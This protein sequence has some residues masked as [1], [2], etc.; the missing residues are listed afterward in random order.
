MTPT[1]VAVRSACMRAFVRACVCVSIVFVIPAAK[2][3]KSLRV[4]K[5]SNNT[6]SFHGHPDIA[7]AA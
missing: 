4:K 6:V 3:C 1:D 5:S 7:G 2:Q